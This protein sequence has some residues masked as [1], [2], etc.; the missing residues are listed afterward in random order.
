MKGEELYNG[1]LQWPN[2]KPRQ[3]ADGAVQQAS[4]PSRCEQIIST[5][6][7]AAPFVRSSSLYA[8]VP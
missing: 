3:I 5:P 6:C 1:V 7:T 2:G 4:P 8:S